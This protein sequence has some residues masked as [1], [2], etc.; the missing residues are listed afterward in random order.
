MSWFFQYLKSL[1]ENFGQVTSSIYRSAEPSSTKLTE[2]RDKYKIGAVMNLRAD[3]EDEERLEVE[4]LKMMWIWVPMADD[5]KPDAGLVGRAIAVMKDTPVPLLVQCKGGRHRT[6]LV[7]ACY[8]VVVQGWSKR[9][10]WDEAKDYGFYKRGE[11]GTPLEKWF[12]NEF[13]PEVF[14]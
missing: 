3:V 1:G 8:R 5:A 7:V 12:W 13:D 14:K 6:G 9:K 11:L 2:Y 10:A 4:A